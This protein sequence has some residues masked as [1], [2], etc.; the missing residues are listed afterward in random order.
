MEGLEKLE[1][2][3]AKDVKDVKSLI[4]K[5]SRVMSVTGYEYMAEQDIRKIIDEDFCGVF[6][7]IYFDKLGCCRLI[8]KGVRKIGGTKKILFDAHL[9]QIG[10]V[11]TEILDGGFLRV[12][13]L[14]GIDN[15]IL[16]ASEFYVY[17]NNSDSENPFIFSP[18]DKIPAIAV[19]IPPHLKN[20]KKMKGDDLP[21]IEDLYLD[22][23]YDSK[24]ELERIVKIGSPVSFKSDFL[25]LENNL[26]S[27]VALDDRLCALTVMFAVKSLKNTP[28]ADVCIV[29]SV[30]EES[31]GLG[32]ETAAFDIQPDFAVVLD[33][34]FAQA[35]E[36]DASGAFEIGKGVGISYS[37][38]TNMSLT[39]KI[40]A[41]A[42]DKR[43][44]IQMIAEP[45]RT[46]TNADAIQITGEG[47][48]CA[49]L[50]VPIKNMHM[51]NEICLIQDVEDAAKLVAAIIE[52]AGKLI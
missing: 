14:G 9:D 39:K 28:E 32:A 26:V 37:A 27:S 47:I 40:V 36:I 21:K 23:G 44:P 19:S 13:S 10:L 5:F 1:R 52:N 20:L 43:I 35:P 17:T 6:D 11:V 8:K 33:V 25:I 30:S 38:A 7:E 15:N 48:P 22:T 34:G 29:L 49:L 16:I 4:E 12:K 45:G 50:S 46:G 41:L 24:E 2:T 51:Q 18:D 31:G 42:K 3:D